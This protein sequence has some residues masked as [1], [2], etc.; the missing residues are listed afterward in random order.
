VVD[1]PTIASQA[2]TSLRNGRYSATNRA[3]SDVEMLHNGG[4]QLD[5]GSC[6]GCR[7]TQLSRCSVP[8]ALE[9]RAAAIRALSDVEL[10]HNGGRQLDEVRTLP[11]NAA[12]RCSVR[13]SLDFRAATTRSPSDVEM[14]HSGGGNVGGSTERFGRQPQEHFR[15]IAF[16]SCCS[17]VCGLRSGV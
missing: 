2:W 3:L 15:E 1:G 11:S 7:R 8:S 12:S 5:K 14:P 16:F 13:S 17:K 10:L 4:G 9:I 6:G